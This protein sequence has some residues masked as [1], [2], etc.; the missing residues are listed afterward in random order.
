MEALPVQAGHHLNPVH[1]GRG[2]GGEPRSQEK[3]GCSC[4]V[5]L[6]LSLTGRQV[7]RAGKEDKLKV[8]A[9]EG[10][11]ESKGKEGFLLPW[12]LAPFR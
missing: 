3:V 10:R 12:P 1:Q 8:S 11:G 4:T 2:W 5:P 7:G 9:P 6:S